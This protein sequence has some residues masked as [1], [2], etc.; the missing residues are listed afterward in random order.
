M[1]VALDKQEVLYRSTKPATAW[2][3]SSTV[4]YS[5]THRHWSLRVRIHRSAQ[6]FAFGARIGVR[7]TWPP[8]LSNTSSKERVSLAS[9]S[10]SRNLIGTSRS[11]RSIAVF[12]ACWVTQAVSGCAVIPARTTLW[13]RESRSWVLSCEFATGVAG[14]R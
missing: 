14:P 2:R 4:S 9:W 5:P 12:L 3:S 7:R 11:L 13:V 6:P 1:A 8:A 10:R